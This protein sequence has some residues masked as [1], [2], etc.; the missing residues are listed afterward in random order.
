M[1]NSEP[2]SGTLLFAVTEL[3]PVTATLSMPAAVLLALPFCSTS[4]KLSVYV[5]G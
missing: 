2:G 3:F 1:S 4:A 5:P